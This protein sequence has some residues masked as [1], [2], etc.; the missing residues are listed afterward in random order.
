MPE[1]KTARERS[2]SGDIDVSP[3]TNCCNTA[4]TS[5]VQDSEVEF[6]ADDNSSL[7]SKPG[8][9]KNPKYHSLPL[10]PPPCT[11]HLFL[12]LSGCSS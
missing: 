1:T 3:F 9:K 5:P 4:H 6:D 8:R 10:L 11:S 2:V 7:P 12:Q